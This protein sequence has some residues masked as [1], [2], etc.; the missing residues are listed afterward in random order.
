[1]G[2]PRPRNERENLCVCEHCLMAI[3][4]R[5]GRQATFAHY[6]SEW[7]EDDVFICDWCDEESDVLYELL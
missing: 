7:S 4:S 6:W 1:M 2:D 3:E 5:E